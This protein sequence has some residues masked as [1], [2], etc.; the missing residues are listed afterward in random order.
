MAW[1]RGARSPALAPERRFEPSNAS[2]RVQ[3]PQKPPGASEGF[4]IDVHLGALA[5]TDPPHV[6]RAI[7]S[8]IVVKPDAV[9]AIVEYALVHWERE[10]FMRADL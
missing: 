6:G 10:N 5:G 9:A 8:L 2:E 4:V 1:L 3:V 7:R